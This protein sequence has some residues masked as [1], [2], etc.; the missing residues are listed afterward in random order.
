VRFPDTFG[1]KTAWSMLGRI[2]KGLFCQMVTIP[3]FK[4]HRVLCQVAG[5]GLA[6]VKLLPPLVIDEGDR[7]WIRDAFDDV[8]ADCENLTGPSGTS[9]ATCRSRVKMSAFRSSSYVRF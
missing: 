4:R 8:I 6:V 1:S 7:A 2:D 9:S 3:L 5:H